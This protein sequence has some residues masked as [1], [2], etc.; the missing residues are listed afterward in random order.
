MHG[1]STPHWLHS[2]GMSQVADEVLRLTGGAAAC[3]KLLY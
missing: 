2:F 3:R 1:T